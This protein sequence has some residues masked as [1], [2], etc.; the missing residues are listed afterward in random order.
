[1]PSALIKTKNNTVWR[2]EYVQVFVAHLNCFLNILCFT[3][4][5]LLFLE[6]QLL[7][8]MHHSIVETRYA[9][10][11]PNYSSA[12]KFNDNLKRSIFN[13]NGKKFYI[14]S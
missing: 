3:Y 4:F 10:L 9:I 6:F 2:K 8:R 14:S 7:K 1:M 11:V 12:C 5:K 13:N